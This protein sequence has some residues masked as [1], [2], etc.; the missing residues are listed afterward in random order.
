MT[1]TAIITG[2]TSGIGRALALEL[3]AR[4]YKLGLTGRRTSMLESLST[5][6]ATESVIKTMDVTNLEESQKTLIALWDE[7]GSAN[8]LVLNAG[9]ASYKREFLWEDENRIIQTNVTGFCNLLNAYWNR[10]VEMQSP[11]HI[12]GISSVA[13]HIPNGGSS[14]YNASKAFI[15]NYMCGLQIKA[16]KQNAP[17]TITDIKPGFVETPMTERNKNM[18]WVSNS[19]KAARQIADAI[20]KKKPNVYITRRWRIIGIVAQMIPNSIYRKFGI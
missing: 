11:G 17:L 19:E 4:G 14:A 13:S 6:L 2:A 16:R 18:F 15:S 10:C 5:E 7:L 1:K 12:V 3:S 8:I 20:E 9:V